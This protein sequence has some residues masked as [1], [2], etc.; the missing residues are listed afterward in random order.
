MAYIT[1]DQV[2]AKSESLKALNKQY[3][4]KATFSG[5]NSSTLQLTISA[6]KID[7]IENFCKVCRAGDRFFETERHL[8]YAKDKQY[9][10]LNHYY[11]DQHFD[12]IALE[13]L[14]KAYAIM[15]QDHWDESDIQTDYF[16]CSWYNG[17]QVGR[18]NKPFELIK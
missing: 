7:F 10:Q 1:K 17:I 14:E 8:G 11:M 6:A 2:K 3:G 18:W 9:V 13:Y 12:G 15:N 5:S 16:H 4:V